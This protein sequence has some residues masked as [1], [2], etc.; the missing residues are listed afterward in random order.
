MKK[1]DYLKAVENINFT[2]EQKKLLKNKIS[3]RTHSVPI[4]Q[5]K[6]FRSVVATVLSLILLTGAIFLPL[7]LLRSQRENI[8]DD[9]ITSNPV[10]TIDDTSGSENS[11]SNNDN[12]DS[13][14]S[15]IPDWYEPGELSVHTMRSSCTELFTQ[16]YG[17]IVESAP[18]VLNN[19]ITADEN[20]TTDII[21][22]DGVNFNTCLYATLLDVDVTSGE[23]ANC[24]DVYYDS[25]SG[26]ITCLSCMIE[27]AIAASGINYQYPG[28]M[29]CNADLTKV[30]FMAQIP[31]ESVTYLLYDVASNSF[32]E[33]PILSNSVM[34]FII[35]P[36]FRYLF[37]TDTK[38]D[39][40]ICAW[41]AFCLDL[42][43]LDTER[44]RISEING[45]S[46]CTDMNIYITPSGKIAYFQ[47][48]DDNGNLNDGT[49]ARWMIYHT[50]TKKTTL[51]EG[52][53][54]RFADHDSMVAVDTVNG[55]VII[56]TATGEAITDTA[57]LELYEKYN[58]EI[59]AS[60][61]SN[62]AKT[63]TLEWKHFVGDI[64]T[65]EKVSM[66]VNSYLIDGEYLYTYIDGNS[67]VSINSLLNGESF[68]IEVSDNFIKTIKNQKTANDVSFHLSIDST[69]T[70]CLLYYAA[71]KKVVETETYEILYLPDKFIASN[72][73]AEMSNFIEGYYNLNK[74]RCT[75]YK[76]DGFNSLVICSNSSFTLALVEDY[77]NSTFTLYELGL[78]CLYADNRNF[79][80]G[81]FDVSSFNE[82]KP[83]Y[84]KFRKVLDSSATS[85]KTLS[86][87][88]YI[89]VSDA[90]IDYAD[91]Y[92]GEV[93]DL[94]KIYAYIN[95]RENIL[96]YL[97]DGFV[98]NVK[99]QSDVGYGILNKELFGELLDIA[100]EQEFQDFT[101]SQIGKYF[102]VNGGATNNTADYTIRCTTYI[103]FNASYESYYYFSV[104]IS[105]EG[106]KYVEHNGHFAY[107]DD[108]AYSRLCEI[109]DELW[110]N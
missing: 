41:D 53:I 34:D 9:E 72:S 51:L 38:T 70:H 95:S 62:Y 36:D 17:C 13:Q 27:D 19:G 85:D 6:P 40:Y 29:K 76:G 21:L 8:P 48:R 14:I 61:T 108:V 77:R 12:S 96:K 15:G 64:N 100:S 23:H 107:I 3:N 24:R 57:R 52:E 87:F 32:Q 80:Y 105:T 25:V 42:T 63:Y 67:Y 54:L 98:T 101:L 1:D 97:T 79:I 83:N 82:T 5:K 92:N 58:V 35:T 33:L 22:P 94:T 106:K 43:S 4:C 59:T 30:V 86:L 74:D 18:V 90:Y 55:V 93:L 60:S 89:T 81:E 84:E 31:G 7:A 39:A 66:T 28:V 91:F 47:L 69:R 102:L 16:E 65:T 11:E 73:L 75:M 37:Y 44:L 99:V 88:N 50:E 104:G 49:D 26:K 71:H 46:Y 68:Q 110:N 109:C 2:D 103:T 56:D 78:N 45:T 10:A 20:S